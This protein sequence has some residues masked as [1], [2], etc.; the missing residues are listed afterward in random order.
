MK[1]K[2]QGPIHREIPPGDTITRLV[3]HECNYIAYENPKV[4]VGTLPEHEG[5]ILLVRRAIQPRHGFWTLP[6]GFLE[7][8]ETTEEGAM[9]ETYEEATARVEIRD[10]LAIYNIKRISQVQFFYRATLLGPDYAPGPESLEVGLFRWEE[11]PWQYLAFPT[12]EWV[13]KAWH[14]NRDRDVLAPVGNPPGGDGTLAEFS[15][16]YPTPP[17]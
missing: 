12:V 9:R 17:E 10:L 8:N 11:I 15:R 1:E 5:R 16:L 3:C 14:E 7:L 4:V 6:A 2:A 13:L